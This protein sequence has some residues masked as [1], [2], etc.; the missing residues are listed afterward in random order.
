M[1]SKKNSEY[2][3]KLNQEMVS[4]NRH[5][6]LFLDNASSHPSLEFS[7][8]KLEY[9][10]P[11]TTSMLQPLD[12][13][14]IQAFKLNY[15]KLILENL[16]TKMGECESSNELVKSINVLD[17]INFSF[18]AN[19]SITPTCIQKCFKNCGFQLE[20]TVEE[21]N[22]RNETAEVQ[23]MIRS[24]YEDNSISATEYLTVDR[25]CVTECPE[26]ELESIV[27]LVQSA[28]NDADP[29]VQEMSEEEDA[30][31]Q[32]EEE[33]VVP[34]SEAFECLRGLE[35]FFIQNYKTEM[36]NALIDI[37][38]QLIKECPNKKKV[39]S[40]LNSFVYNHQ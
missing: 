10:P 15:R 33:R 11:N 39:Q 14:I 36:Y 22:P 9:F 1:T 5:I 40:N 8:I 17:A 12:A 37:K 29:V 6:L 28:K 34:V 3:A 25:N 13:G 2:L 32:N 27:A 24:I 26:I 31:Q 16:L 4:K 23:N 19:K 7:N 30:D 38:F 20:D 21:V 18:Q 35:L